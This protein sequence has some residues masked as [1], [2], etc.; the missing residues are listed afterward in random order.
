MT[1][2]IKNNY[3]KY[4]RLLELFNFTEE[5]EKR[6]LFDFKLFSRNGTQVI[7]NIKDVTCGSTCCLV[8]NVSLLFPKLR[9]LTK[10]NLNNRENIGRICKFLFINPDMY[11][12]LFY[13]NEYLDFGVE[14]IEL[15]SSF[16]VIKERYLRAIELFN[17]KPA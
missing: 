6:G 4:D 7:Y 9:L 13:G 10:Q 1:T 12:C 14:W 17:N 15:E 8:G 16:P 5:R 11:A 2:V 3:V